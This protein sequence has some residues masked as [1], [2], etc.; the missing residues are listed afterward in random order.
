MIRV[1]S[2]RAPKDGCIERQARRLDRRLGDKSRVYI[3]LPSEQSKSRCHQLIRQWNNDDLI[4]FMGHGRSDGLVGSRGIFAGMMGED[5]ALD[6]VSDLFYDDEYFI[7][8]DSFHLFAGKKV[9]CFACESDLLG[10]KLVTAGATAIVGFGKMPSSKDEFVTERYDKKMIT[11]AMI[12]AL[13]G[14]I[15][16]AFRDA[17]IRAVK[18]QGVMA[19]VA[20]YFKM[21]TRKQVSQLLH[22][23]ARY[24][25]VLANILYD[26]S[27]TVMVCGNK[28]LIV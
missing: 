21:E 14:T 7:D 19:D 17:V 11:Q 25:Y 9:V 16:V 1:I 3:V 23:K 24:R 20:V 5:D 26:I 27:K 12:S 13:N 6:K 4:V 8:A 18:M 28:Q 10:E 22:S 15:N 2:P